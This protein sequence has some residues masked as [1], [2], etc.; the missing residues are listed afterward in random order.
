MNNLKRGYKKQL[1]V[2]YLEQNRNS[3]EEKL[4]K[5]YTP[6]GEG[7]TKEGLQITTYIFNPHASR[8]EVALMRKDL[9]RL[10]REE[11]IYSYEFRNPGVT[12]T[13]SSIKF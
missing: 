8:N 13:K 10:Q 1:I 7:R 9:D 3:L 11:I 12:K 6:L 5:N 2:K 4:G